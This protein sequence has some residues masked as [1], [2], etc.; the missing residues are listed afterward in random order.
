MGRVI[1]TR[2]TV[3]CLVTPGWN[4]GIGLLQ[5]NYL[6]FMISLPIS[7]FVEQFVV[8]GKLLRFTVP[9]SISKEEQLGSCGVI[10]VKYDI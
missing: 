8:M 7:W 2:G 9:R 10:V 4:R 6:S 5:D 1:E 3:H